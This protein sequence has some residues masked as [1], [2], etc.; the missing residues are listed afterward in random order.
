[1]EWT[2]A[3]SYAQI[4]DTPL[5]AVSHRTAC[6]SPRTWN[7]KFSILVESEEKDLIGDQERELIESIFEF[8]DT[9]VREIMVPRTEI[10]AVERN[11]PLNDI[12]RLLL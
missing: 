4:P 8:K 10:I 5:A 1:M 3:K 9:L 12:F 7:G 6:S 11:T 2:K